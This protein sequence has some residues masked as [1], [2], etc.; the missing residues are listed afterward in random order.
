MLLSQVLRL[1]L[2]KCFPFI[3]THSKE[4]FRKAEQE[5]SESSTNTANTLYML[6]D[7]DNLDEATVGTKLL[8][9]VDYLV[10][11]A[12]ININ[13][14]DVVACDRV[15]VRLYGGWYE[16]EIPTRKAQDIL[17]ALP[18]LP[19]LFPFKIKNVHT[20]K[21]TWRV[22][23]E[24]AFGL[25]SVP[26]VHMMHTYRKRQRLSGIRVVDPLSVGCDPSKCRVLGIKKLVRN[27]R[28]PDCGTDA[29]RIIWRTEQKLVDVML[30]T[31]LLTLSATPDTVVCVVS[32]DDDIWPAMFHVSCNSHRNIYHI[33]GIPTRRMKHLYTRHAEP[34]YVEIPIK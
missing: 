26:A 14:E 12:S 18:T 4:T 13:K 1:L 8:D 21:H 11:H 29:N 9:I 2:A 16:N 3:H 33:H 28:C 25:F 17:A 5:M 31:D 6:V 23:V 32:S 30:A 15:V 22:R 20:E 24:L 19:I 27:N 7:F 34:T 10:R